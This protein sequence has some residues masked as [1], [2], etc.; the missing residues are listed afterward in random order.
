MATTIP[1]YSVAT[2]T[3]VQVAQIASGVAA[4]QPYLLEAQKWAPKF[5][6]E[7]AKAAGARSTAEAQQVDQR[8][9]DIY[10][11]LR[12]SAGYGAAVKDWE[13]RQQAGS[14][15]YGKLEA[16]ALADVARGG[17][18]DPWQQRE[19]TQASRAAFEDRGMATGG[20]AALAEVMNR[21]NLS[22]ARR[23]EREGYAAGIVNQAQGWAGN[24]VNVASTQFDP[25][26]RMFGKGGSQVTG[27][28]SS[29]EM[30]ET[31]G[32]VGAS[33]Y[34]SNTEAAI[35]NAQIAAQQKM[36]DK[37]MKYDKWA[38]QY[39]ASA[40]DRIGA[41]NAS[42]ARS[43]GNKQLIG[44]GIGAVGMVVAAALI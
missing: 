25:Y 8:W 38:T 23:R 2:G 19:A 17:T 12:E 14:Q 18:L 39:N 3:G 1:N 5:A 24:N 7:E 27:S 21:A 20:T 15:I 29:N 31:Y 36:F 32:S 16:N 4:S 6:E 33:I 9:G 43:A 10:S 37:Q 44:A 34:G 11:G 28:L 42:A 35:A 40:S 13:A 41:M 26:S 30:Y 22:E